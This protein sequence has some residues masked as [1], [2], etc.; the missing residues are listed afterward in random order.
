MIPFTLDALNRAHA[1]AV[2]APLPVTIAPTAPALAPPVATAPAPEPEPARDPTARLAE[3][4][5]KSEKAAKK[6]GGK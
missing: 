6:K 2:P 4:L 5:L 1:A 3:M